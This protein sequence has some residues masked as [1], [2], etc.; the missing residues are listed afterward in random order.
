M[1]RGEQ[2]GGSLGPHAA[3]NPVVLS[4]HLA[5]IDILGRPA[6]ERTIER[7]RQAEIE[8]V[9]VIV[10]SSVHGQKAFV[11]E[12]KNVECQIVS[13]TSLAVRNKLKEYANQGI[14][15]SFVATANLYA[16]TDF[17][18]LFYFHREGRHPV[19]HARDREGPLDLCVVDCE[20]AQDE[21]LENLFGA[22]EN[23]GSSYFIREY[24]NRLNHV[25]DLRRIISD[26]FRKRCAMR[27]TGHEVKSGI[28][29]DD[30][31][32]IHRKARIVSPAYIGRGVTLREDTLVTRCSNVEESCYV[33]YGTVI[34]DSSI[35]ENTHIGIWLDV[36][37]SIADGNTLV[38]LKRDVALEITD[39]SVMRSTVSRE[40]KSGQVLNKLP[41]AESEVLAVHKKVE[42]PAQEVCSWQPILSRGE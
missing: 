6:I 29:V 16:E 11:K 1:L 13:E 20:K 3:K 26:V 4:E 22:Q 41:G 14:E 18:D 21:D 31:A 28:W 30:E 7:L 34:E 40:T 37:S 19:T 9:S 27:P 39:P 32:E 23:N 10:D 12:L 38:S 33:D 35:L 17:L 25:A 24:V 36:C 15:H 8:A 42:L 5:C 2:E